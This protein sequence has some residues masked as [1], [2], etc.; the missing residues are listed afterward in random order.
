VEF[1]SAANKT[2]IMV[3]PEEWIE[4]EIVVLGEISQV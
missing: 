1:Y 3:L 4:L 2:E